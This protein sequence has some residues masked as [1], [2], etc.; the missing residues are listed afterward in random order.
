MKSEEYKFIAVI[1]GL[2]SVLGNLLLLIPI[3]LTLGLWLLGIP[4]DWANWKTYAGIAAL[5]FAVVL[6]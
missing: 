3:F 2:I 1:F 4:L 5:W 6:A